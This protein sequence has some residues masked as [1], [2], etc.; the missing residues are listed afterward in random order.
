VAPNTP[1][2]IRVYYAAWFGQGGTH[3]IC[4]SAGINTSVEMPVAADWSVYPNP[5]DG[6][7]IVRNL[8]PGTMA[9]LRLVD[10]A[11]RTVWS[12]RTRLEARATVTVDRSGLAPG[13]YSLRVRADGR[14]IEKR[15]VVE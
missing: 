10:V 11:G 3:A 13:V 12:Q 2:L 1:Y 7:F 15:V 8:G 5:N 6:S 4:V 14:S 9:D